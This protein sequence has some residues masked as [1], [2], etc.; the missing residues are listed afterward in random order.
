[1]AIASLT[2]GRI[3][4]GEFEYRQGWK[5]EGTDLAI[6]A[7]TTWSTG[8]GYVDVETAGLVQIVI[9]ATGANAGSAGVVTFSFVAVGASTGMTVPVTA[10]FTKTLT[11][12]GT[13]AKAVDFLVDCSAYGKLKLLSVANGDASQALA[14]VNA[15]IFWKIKRAY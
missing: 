7:N 5:F 3:G 6:N 14:E 4:G 10:S 12:A 11:V 9:K 2:G 13:T 15:E 8:S 1:M